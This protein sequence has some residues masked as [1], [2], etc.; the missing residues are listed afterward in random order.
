[1]SD[2]VKSTI[3][4]TIIIG[5][6]MLFSVKMATSTMWNIARTSKQYVEVQKADIKQ[7]IIAEKRK[8]KEVYLEAAQTQAAVP[9]AKPV[10]K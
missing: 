6:F 7:F 5:I 3:I 4:G 8:A 1:M 9:A 10:K 2:M